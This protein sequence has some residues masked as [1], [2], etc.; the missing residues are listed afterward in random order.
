MNEVQ[1]FREKSSEKNRMDTVE[2]EFTVED[3]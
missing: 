2:T 1:T 3:K